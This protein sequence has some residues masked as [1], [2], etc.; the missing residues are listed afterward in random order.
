MRFIEIAACVATACATLLASTVLD[1]C[2]GNSGTSFAP[3]LTKPPAQT[4]L[5]NASPTFKV[6]S[7]TFSNNGTVPISMVW[8]HSGSGCAGGNR[9]PQLRWS[10][11]PSGTKT[12]AIV[13]F[14]ETARFTHWGIYD[15]PASTTSLPANAGVPGSK[16]GLQVINDFFIAPEY[17]GPCPPPG[18]VHHY[19]ITVY[20]MNCT[21]VLPSYPGF[22]P[23]AETLLYALLTNR[24]MILA[25]TSITGLYSK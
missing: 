8:N 13:M 1:G 4:A 21:L 10:G 19:V 12:Y 18:L 11:A 25:S 24:S 6:T 23:A 5:T 14:D 7:T 2:G 20:A 9:S 15:I 22:P 3:G 16:Y 17:D